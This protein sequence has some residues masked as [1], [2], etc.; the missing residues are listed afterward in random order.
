MSLPSGRTVLEA[1][2]VTGEGGGPDKTILNTPRFMKARG[3]PTV[4]TYLRPP[5]DPG[6]AAIEERATRWEAPLEVVD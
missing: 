1:R 6:F 2:I 3:Y 4:C 5:S